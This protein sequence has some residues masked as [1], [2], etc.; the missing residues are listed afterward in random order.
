MRKIFV[1]T[2]GRSDY[3]IYKPLLE[4]LLHQ[5]G[6]DLKLVAS[7]MH[8]S[9]EFGLSI[10]LIL[11]DGY[12]I[13]HRVEMLLGSDTP[14]AI[15]KSIGLGVIGFSQVYA[16]EQPDLLVVLGDRFE[17]YAAALATLPFKIPVAHIHG[18]EL[19]QGAMDDVL[20][21]SMTKLSH[22]HFTATDEYARRVIQ[23]GEEPWRVVACGALGLENI[24]SYHKLDRSQMEQKLGIKLS[25]PPIIVTYHPVT[26]EFENAA[27]QIG[28]LLGALESTQL[29][30]V[31]TKANA[32]T[33]GRIINREI[34]RFVGNH[35]KSV[36]VDNLGTSGYFSLMSMAGIMVGNSSSGILEAASFHLP[37]VNIGNRQKGRTHANN[38]IDVDYPREA[39]WQ[40]IEKGLSNAFRNG[41][42]N[43]INP[44]FKPDTAET[45]ASRLAHVELDHELIAKGF[46]DL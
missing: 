12:P 28:E 40:G 45:I 30:I 25:Q 5:P 39:I 32:D 26:F 9:P 13:A 46:H 11:E 44:Y 20:R 42:A 43:L 34:E 3:G 22:L 16:Q 36:L 18:G 2:V 21:H 14:Q 35:E 33:N 10:N 6:V 1:V 8:L 19:T 4:A 37:V 41:L 38:V 23:M 31:F 29:P 27:W 15:A 17:M 24:R 7:G